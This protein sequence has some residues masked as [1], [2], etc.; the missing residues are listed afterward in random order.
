MA[1]TLQRLPCQIIQ[2]ADMPQDITVDF[3]ELDL[4]VPST[5]WEA[6]DLWAASD[7]GKLSKLTRTVAPH[8]CIMLVLSPVAPD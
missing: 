1:L 6:R 8:D 3:G 4:G 7:L 5:T 2:G